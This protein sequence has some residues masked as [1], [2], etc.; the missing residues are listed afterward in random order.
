MKWRRLTHPDFSLD[1]SY[2]EVTP[3]GHA[4]KRDD[5]PFMGYTRVHLSSP[6]TRE[7]YIEVVRFHDLAPENDY[8]THRSYLE[9]RFGKGSVTG[10]TRTSL[11]GRPAWAYGFRWDEGERAVRLLEVSGETYRL[12]YEPRSELNH[13]VI[14]T[15]TIPEP[16]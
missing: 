9:Q 6:E 13:Q 8:L 11:S 4:V 14:A 15:L 16:D 10:L 7:L 3:Q 2:P 5:Q 12:L 1:F